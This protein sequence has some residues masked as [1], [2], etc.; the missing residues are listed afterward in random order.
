[1]IKK[2]R[3]ELEKLPI[4]ILKGLDISSPEEEKLIQE[5]ILSKAVIAQP[6]VKFNKLIPDIKSPEDEKQ[7]QD[8]IDAFNLQNAPVEAKIV[9]AEKTLEIVNAMVH[10]QV[11]EV[12]TPTV[13]TVKDGEIIKPFCDKC[14]SKG[15]RH[16]KVCPLFE[17]LNKENAD[18]N[19][20]TV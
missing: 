10:E 9:S 15:V 2:T 8:K 6:V 20:S 18:I 4:K 19:T 16:K 11:P 3:E 17:S 13:V 14:D 5:I 12:V 7:W 1:M